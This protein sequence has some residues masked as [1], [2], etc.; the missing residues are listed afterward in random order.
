MLVLGLAVAIGAALSVFSAWGYV[1]M[2]LSLGAFFLARRR[3]S[4]E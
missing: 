3:R 1:A 2:I 4:L